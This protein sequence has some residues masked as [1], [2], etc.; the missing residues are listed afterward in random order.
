[1]DARER[2]EPFG[3]SLSDD[4]GT[5]RT[6]VIELMFEIRMRYIRNETKRKATETEYKNEKTKKKK[7]MKRRFAVQLFTEN[8]KIAQTQV[9]HNHNNSA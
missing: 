9:D 7:K 4:D 6:I 5:K 1:M 8:V 2:L 3:H